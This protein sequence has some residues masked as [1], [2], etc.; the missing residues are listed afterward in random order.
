[1]AIVQQR[2]RKKDPSFDA[3][4]WFANDP[5]VDMVDYGDT[6]FHSAMDEMFCL[7]MH[8][9]K[10]SKE[11]Y[12]EQLPWQ[13]LDDL[14]PLW[15]KNVQKEQQQSSST[16]LLSSSLLWSIFDI[17]DKHKMAVDRLGKYKLHGWTYGYRCV[18]V[19]SLQCNFMEFSLL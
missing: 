15:E 6:F 19:N 14:Q 13:L 12:P 5:V 7:S 18:Y 2:A 4:L 1:M 17:C 8:P 3:P 10:D 11:P 16:G 9:P